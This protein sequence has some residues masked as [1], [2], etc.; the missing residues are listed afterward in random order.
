[1]G[2]DSAHGAG[3]HRDLAAT[4]RGQLSES[5]F[6][7]RINELAD[8]EQ[9]LASSEPEGR[10]LLI[11]GDSGS[12]KTFFIN[13]LLRTLH[14]KAS[15]SLILYVDVAN[16]DYQS[17]RVLSSLL[18]LAVV[19][20]PMIGT[21]VISVPTELSLQKFLKERNVRGLGRG[22]IK[23]MANSLGAVF[24]LGSTVGAI[25][26]DPSADKATRP[27]HEL[28]A[29]LKWVCRAKRAF[30]AVDNIQFLN[31]DDRLTIESTIQRVG[32]G[33][34]AILID[35]T[36]KGKSQLAQPVRCFA[37]RQLEL[38]IERFTE[39]ETREV[40]GRFFVDKFLSPADDVRQKLSTDVFIKTGGLAK[41][42]EYCLTGYKLEV[43]KGAHTEAVHGLLS[44][45]HRLPLIHRQF[46][47]VATLLE[48]GVDAAIAHG[49]VARL[50]A[51]TDSA[52]LERVVAELVDSAYLRVNGPTGNRLRP[53]HERIVSAIGE[54]SDEELQEDVRRS[55]VAELAEALNQPTDPSTETYLLH[56]LVGLQ[57]AHELTRN[58]D[59]ISRLIQGQHRQD[60]FSYLTTLADELHEVLSLL[61][62]H[63]LEDL[64]DSFQKSS[65][66]EKGL[67]VLH[68][69]DVSGIPSTPARDAYRVRYLTQ[70]YRYRQALELSRKLRGRDDWVKLNT[71]TT[72]MAL[73]QD[74]EAHH[75]ALEM[76]EP[77]CSTEVQA[78]L[79]RNTIHLYDSH[80]A[81]LHLDE[82]YRYFERDASVFRLA[83]IQ[84]NRSLVHLHRGAL[85]DAE[86]VL[87]QALDS[88]RR[89]DSR[90][91]YQAQINEAIRLAVVGDWERSLSLLNEA[92]VHVPR[93]LTFD[94]VKIDVNLA[95]LSRISDQYSQD[96]CSE[97]LEDCLVF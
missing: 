81:L 76:L 7:G 48:A 54:L 58:I 38:V 97:A 34:S 9:W 36:V 83:T 47:V 6:V 70:A 69:L 29:Y 43:S 42:I 88:M 25:L 46:L 37:N 24:G 77:D 39:A 95:V 82:A 52:E 18:K 57:T 35:R 22:I 67:Q 27:E 75:R 65:A 84:T 93:S 80:T 89:V 94:Q 96:E 53:G 16:D 62:A 64:L 78:V 19:P 8:A 60:Q 87:D 85:G 5:P 63:V 10:L 1:M 55:L 44:T 23:A 91:I 86:R 4:Q 79:R 15:D 3:R 33:L 59:Q 90:E 92:A 56:C 74:D 30:L 68:L 66:F 11:R 31:L 26:E 32:A 72:L 71:I 13:Q 20:G 49:T 51:A 61:P 40:V 50:A 2:S 41:D 28:T 45:I 21:S 14:S 17:A 12:G 73:G